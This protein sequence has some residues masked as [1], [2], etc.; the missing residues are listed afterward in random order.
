MERKR[1]KRFGITE[2]SVME[3][4]EAVMKAYVVPAARLK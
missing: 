1:P 2:T 4:F 3:K